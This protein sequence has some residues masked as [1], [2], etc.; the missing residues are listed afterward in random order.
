MKTPEQ[1]LSEIELL[2]TEY[3]NQKN[4]ERIEQEQKSAT[5]NEIIEYICDA[6]GLTPSEI[7]SN[8]RQRRIVEP[9]QLL[10]TLLKLGLLISYN[11]VGAIIGNFDHATVLHAIKQV[12]NRYSMY[13][14]YRELVDND[15]ENLFPSEQVQNYIKARISNP[16]LDRNNSAAKLYQQ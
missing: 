10:A 15:I 12:S 3:T 1:I 6:N 16:H 5:V 11:E 7:R 2:M 13:P 8:T 4:L 14:I 9:R